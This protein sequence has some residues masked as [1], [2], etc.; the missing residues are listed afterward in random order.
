MK[1]YE[2]FRVDKHCYR[3][4]VACKRSAAPQNS[5]RWHDFGVL[6]RQQLFPNRN[7]RFAAVRSDPP[8][9]VGMSACLLLNFWMEAV[10]V[11]NL[12]T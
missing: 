11:V 4:I 9:S 8:P 6:K 7:S 2:N 3:M 1:L 12:A 10:K 5:N